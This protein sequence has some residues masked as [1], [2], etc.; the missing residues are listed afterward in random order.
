MGVPFL[1]VEF[2]S[3]D[4]SDKDWET[5]LK[6]LK[7]T[8]SDIATSK[9]LGQWIMGFAV[10]GTEYQFFYIENGEFKGDSN[11][12]LDLYDPEGQDWVSEDALHRLSTYLG[13]IQAHTPAK[14]I[15]KV[16]QI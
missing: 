1:A 11:L 13:F 5:C 7:S 16:S 12:V 14:T 8:M 6:Q 10:A 9:G 4:P 3:A 2:K 15:G